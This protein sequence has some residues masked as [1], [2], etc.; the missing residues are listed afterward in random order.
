MGRIIFGMK[1]IYLK[2]G[3]LKGL[4]LVV[5]II[6]PIIII[7]FRLIRHP[8]GRVAKKQGY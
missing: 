5:F 2:S 4:I 6:I 3:E 7:T 1:T 8:T